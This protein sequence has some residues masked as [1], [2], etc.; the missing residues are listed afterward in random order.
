DEVTI[1]IIAKF[2]C[3]GIKSIR[4]NISLFFFVVM[5]VGN[6]NDSFINDVHSLITFSI[7]TILFANIFFSCSLMSFDKCGVRIFC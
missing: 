4:F 1:R 7:E 2:L 5:I 3:K 6:F